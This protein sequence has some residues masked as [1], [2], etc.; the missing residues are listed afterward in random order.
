MRFRHLGQ[1]HDAL[2]YWSFCL[3]DLIPA[4][5]IDHTT[6][7]LSEGP[8]T[9]HLSKPRSTK[10][11]HFKRSNS[12][13]YSEISIN[14]DLGK[15]RFLFTLVH[16]LAHWKAYRNYGRMIKPH[17][18]EW[19][20]LFKQMILPTVDDEVFDQELIKAIIAHLKSPKAASCSDPVLQRAFDRSEGLDI[21][22]LDSVPIGS[23]FQ[24]KNGRSFIK[25][26][27][28]RT[29]FLCIEIDTGRRFLI[30]GI[31]PVIERSLEKDEI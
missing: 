4:A 23:R 3:R 24:L 30:P 12:S 29:R 6:R 22:T 5:A 26:L 21:M 11:G 14:R 20:S 31:A 19:K 16:E 25:E 10:L 27:K 9:L 17:G 8:I 28:K 13:T 18:V 1:N 7:L 2:E 15:Q